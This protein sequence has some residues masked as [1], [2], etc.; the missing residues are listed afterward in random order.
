M[1][2]ASA[3]GGTIQRLKPGPAI[4]RSRPR[5]PPPEEA[6][7]PCVTVIGFVLPKIPTM[8]FEFSSPA[9]KLSPLPADVPRPREPADRVRPPRP[10]DARQWRSEEP[11][12][13]SSH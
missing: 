11:R 2:M 10:P 8:G 13:N 4:V 3:A 12:L 6:F 1:W 9:A 5:I 7:I